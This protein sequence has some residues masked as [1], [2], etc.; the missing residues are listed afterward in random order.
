MY[1]KSGSRCA[2]R[3]ETLSVQ[4]L[5]IE[6]LI[7]FVVEGERK[8]AQELQKQPPPPQETKTSSELLNK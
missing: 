7:E 5:S 3:K 8:K 6:N 2:V 4:E 1:R